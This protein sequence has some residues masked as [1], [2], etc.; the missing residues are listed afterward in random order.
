M[1]KPWLDTASRARAVGLSELFEARPAE[2]F[3]PSATPDGAAF[4]AVRSL[5]VAEI[6]AYDPTARVL[7]RAAALPPP[8]PELD[9]TVELQAQHAAELAMMRAQVELQATSAARAAYDAELGAALDHAR[10]LI[11]RLGETRSIDSDALGQGLRA[12]VIGLVEQVIDAQ[13]SVDAGFVATRVD[14]ALELLKSELEPGRLHLHP[15]DLAL[16]EDRTACFPNLV[17]V[18][19]PS[20]PR[21]ALRLL[22]AG[23]TI[24]DSTEARI[25][26]LR[27]ELEGAA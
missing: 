8:A 16:V 13:L 1:S 7:G 22:A 20:M 26:R 11:E 18:A 2:P 4:R 25:A 17:L 9:P 27:E 14:R 6:D 19:D 21:G 5:A 12:L 23:G 15:A 10:A 24:E 3:R